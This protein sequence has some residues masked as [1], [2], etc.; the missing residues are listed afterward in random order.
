MTESETSARYVVVSLLEEIFENMTQNLTKQSL[1]AHE[2]NQDCDT[3]A[4]LVRESFSDIPSSDNRQKQ[5]PSPHIA[6]TEPKRR[7]KIE[8]TSLLLRRRKKYK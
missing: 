4:L 6:W 2:G 7:R 3:E 5:N 8:T 1:Q